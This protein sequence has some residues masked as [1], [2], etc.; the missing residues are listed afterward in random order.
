MSLHLTLLSSKDQLLEIANSLAADIKPDISYG[1]EI[2]VSI[3]TIILAYLIGSFSLSHIISKHK[4][5]N[6]KEQGSKNLGASNTLALIGKR[7]GAMV[8]LSDIL[9]VILAITL[10]ICLGTILGELGVPC[11]I[12]IHNDFIRSI[13]ESN[14]LESIFVLC[15]ASAILGHIFPFYL[16]FRGGKGFASYISL[17]LALSI[18]NPIILIIPLLA[19]LI[20]IITNYIVSATFTVILLTPLYM[21]FIQENLQATIILTLVSIVIFIKHIE[22]IKHIKDGSEMKIREAFKNKYKRKET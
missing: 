8:L 6:L 1:I 5:I 2:Y 12:W 21:W 14:L 11:A 15:G 13:Q 4:G 16:K 17:V 20:A 18:L 3:F 7:A 9:K 19:V 22:N 10:C